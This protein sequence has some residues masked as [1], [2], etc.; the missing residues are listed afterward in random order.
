MGPYYGPAEDF[1]LRFGVQ[2][3]TKVIFRT[4][5]G[6]VQQYTLSDKAKQNAATNDVGS[7]YLRTRCDMDQAPIQRASLRSHV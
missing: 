4:S 3:T 1:R 7:A 6:K 5:T 2:D